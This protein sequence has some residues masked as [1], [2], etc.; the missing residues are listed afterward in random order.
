[1]QFFTLTLQDIEVNSVP[2]SSSLTFEG[3]G[4]EDGTM[5]VSSFVK[6]NGNDLD[7]AFEIE[8]GFIFFY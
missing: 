3:D 6:S 5:F 4:M 1:M 7:L 2:S 8:G